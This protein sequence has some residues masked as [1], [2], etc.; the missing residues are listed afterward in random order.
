M[1]RSIKIK[2]TDLELKLSKVVSVDIDKNMIN[3]EQLPNGTW[4]LIYTKKL[5]EDF[6]K[7]E[8][9]EIVRED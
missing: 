1:K 9:F 7:V 4:R 8:A 3:L 2:G 5:I 6:A